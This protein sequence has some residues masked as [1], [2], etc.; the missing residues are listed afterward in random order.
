MQ[1]IQTKYMGKISSKVPS[2]GVG[3]IATTEEDCT[4]DG[5]PLCLPLCD[6]KQQS[7]I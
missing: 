4:S 1:F 5:L 6:Q 3:E 2:S 7:V